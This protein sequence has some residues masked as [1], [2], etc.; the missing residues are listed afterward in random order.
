MPQA[1]TKIKCA[2]ITRIIRAKAVLYGRKECVGYDGEIAFYH[3][4]H[5]GKNACPSVDGNTADTFNYSF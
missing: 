5:S 3:E 1:K 4:I 2:A